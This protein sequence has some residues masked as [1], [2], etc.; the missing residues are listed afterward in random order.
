MR[1]YIG[2]IRLTWKIAPGLAGLAIFVVFAQRRTK[3]R[4]ELDIVFGI[5]RPTG[6]ANEARKEADK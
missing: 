5:A 6:Q 1:A 4:T 3:L 2:S